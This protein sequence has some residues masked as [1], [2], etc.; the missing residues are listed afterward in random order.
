MTSHAIAFLALVSLAQAIAPA[1]SQDWAGWMEK[2]NILRHAANFPEAIAAYQEA[3]KILEPKPAHDDLLPLASALNSVGSSYDDMGRPEDAEKYYHRA[4]DV[5]VSVAGL[6]SV[7]RAQIL[8]NLACSYLHR[9]ETA[10]AE[11]TIR[12]ALAIFD[13]MIP[14]DSLLV[15]IARSYLAAAQLQRGLLDEA[16]ALMD[17]AV[18]VLEKN[19]DHEGIYGMVLNNLGSLRWDQHRHDESIRLFRQ[20]L[21]ILEHDR[22]A[23]SPALLYPLNNLASAKFNTGSKEE[24]IALYSRAVKIAET[25][26]GPYSTLY[27]H[28]LNNYA[29]CLKKTG[30]KAE[31]KTMETRAAAVRKNAPWPVGS[32]LTV[33]INALRAR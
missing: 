32:G 25:R 31:A 6:R 24:A 12:E 33:D 11:K 15:A 27:G 17:Q 26:L 23:D 1:Q 19:V 9:G 10:R 5:A 20:S 29:T 4:I 18:P 3:I 13:G 22:G 14:S 28:L 30:H 8:V 21:D 16:S 7:S 2:G